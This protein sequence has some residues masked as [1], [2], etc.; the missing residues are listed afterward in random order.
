M[1]LNETLQKKLETLQHILREKERVAVA[2]S[3]GVDSA[4]LL[5]AAHSVFGENAIAVTVEGD[6]MTGEEMEEAKAFAAEYGI[7][8]Y[9]LPV[10]IFRLRGF[11]ENTPDR[12]YYCKQFLFQKMLQFTNTM[13]MTL[14]EGSN[15]DDLSDYRPGRIALENLNVTSP[16]VAAEL[17]KD[18]IRQIAKANGLS[19][20]NKP[21]CACL[22]SRVPYYTEITPEILLQIAQ[23]ETFLHALGIAQVRVRHHGELA[24]IET[25]EA[26]MEQMFKDSRMI[27]DRLKMF[28]YQYITMDLEPYR[29]GRLNEML[30]Q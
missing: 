23:A 15:V 3:G 27:A 30:E 16:L 7:A 17:T 28:G 10:D 14:V 8:H 1:I 21:S 18:E 4:F 22:A 13:K 12:C 24:R 29:T 6:M 2:Y 19:V 26:G 25:D 5:W 11:C 20:W 9:V